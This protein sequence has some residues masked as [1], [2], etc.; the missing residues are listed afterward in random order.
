MVL[1]AVR[2]EPKN[3]KTKKKK[4]LHPSPKRKPHPQPS[5]KGRESLSGES[6]DS[7]GGND[8]VVADQNNLFWSITVAS[9]LTT[10]PPLWKSR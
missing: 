3:E 4:I 8:L 5:L 1:T 2:T 6:K 10:E 9:L 7:V